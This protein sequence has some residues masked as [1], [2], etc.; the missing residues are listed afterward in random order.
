[1]VTEAASRELRAI[2]L[3]METLDWAG[4]VLRKTPERHADVARV[5][6]TEHERA[7]ELLFDVP[8]P[9]PPSRRRF[10]R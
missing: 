9:T 7:Q 6:K 5:C 2:A 3:L 1:M 8:I 10:R 4:E